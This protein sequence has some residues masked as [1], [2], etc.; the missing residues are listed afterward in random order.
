MSAPAQI[1]S[2]GSGEHILG[3][4]PVRRYPP[5]VEIRSGGAR[6]ARRLTRSIKRRCSGGGASRAAAT[7]GRSSPAPEVAGALFSPVAARTAGRY[8]DRSQPATARSA[9][10]RSAAR[11]TS[12]DPQQLPDF[13]WMT[14]EISEVAHGRS[15]YGAVSGVKTWALSGSISDSCSARPP[16][17]RPV[18]SMPFRAPGA[19]RIFSPSMVGAGLDRSPWRH[20]CAD[21]SSASSLHGWVRIWRPAPSPQGPITG[22]QQAMTISPGVGVPV[23]ACAARGMHDAMPEPPAVASNEHAHARR[24][25]GWSGPASILRQIVKMCFAKSLRS[26]CT[27]VAAGSSAQNHRGDLLLAIGVQ[28]QRSA[29][30]EFGLKVGL[31]LPRPVC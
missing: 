11:C 10:C 3:N 31:Q 26:T 12:V 7:D 6:G 19:A 24:R 14:G 18:S 25:S 23:I 27:P 16:M 21:S 17:P 4:L 22:M 13:Q 20:Q 2:Q 15:Q 28:Q 30:T 29:C 5:I 9:G 8:D 1:A